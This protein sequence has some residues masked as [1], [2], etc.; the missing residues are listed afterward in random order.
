MTCLLFFIF[1]LLNDIDGEELNKDLP[2]YTSVNTFKSLANFIRDQKN[3]FNPS[4]VFDGA[5][6]F[7]RAEYIDRF[8]KNFH[9]QINN[10]Y[11]LIT[12]EGDASSPRLY[13]KYLNDD[14]LIAWLGQNP[15]I[16]NHP[17]FHPIPIGIAGRKWPSGNT[18]I[19]SKIQNKDIEREHLV[20]LNIRVKTYPFERK[21][22]QNLFQDKD[23]CFYAQNRNFEEY[24]LDLKKS[25]F[26]FSPRGNGL[27]CHRTWEAILM[28]CIPIVRASNLDPLLEDLP[29]LIIENWQQINKEYLERKKLEL[30][31]KSY[32]IDKLFIHYWKTY[33]QNIL[34]KENLL[35]N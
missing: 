6:I 30:K 7:V 16:D 21:I 25:V 18:S 2:E 10:R 9:P 34:R 19:I 20:Y 35:E 23:Y 11:I 3:T 4:D 27:D 12:H 26:T 28:G 29:V 15:S 24:L 13:I 14:K 17:K 22:V 1:F 33:I 8:F 5:I 31:E 32:S